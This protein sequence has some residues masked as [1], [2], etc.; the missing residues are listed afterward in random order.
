MTPGI[1]LDRSFRYCTQVIR[2]HAK[3]FYF[4][5]HFLPLEKRQAVFA[6]YAFY[7][8]V[9]D[10]V[11]RRSPGES[12]RAVVLQLD[13]WR[14]WLLDRSG[15][16]PLEPVCSALGYVLDR[17]SV[18]VWYLAQLLDGV[19]SD[20]QPRRL[21]SFDELEHY[22]YQV[23]GT[24]GLVMASILGTQDDA[25]LLRARD[26]GIAMQLTNVLRDVGEDLDRQ[27]IY[28]PADELQRFRYSPERLALR[29][30]DADL[31]ALLRMQIRRARSYYRSGLAGIPALPRDSQFP[32]YLAARMYGAILHKIERGGYDVFSRRAR[33]RLPEKVLL[34]GHSYLALRRNA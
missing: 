16:M 26:L 33:T 27:M 34:A 13:A 9:D 5:S 30:V 17:Y 28:L 8:T 12:P 32:I 4:A 15:P 18:P 19:Q 31:M 14:R 6:L 23:A 22:C 21:Q 7:R 3:S 20:L 11:D 25:A 29:R 24:V 2:E 10:C 1:D